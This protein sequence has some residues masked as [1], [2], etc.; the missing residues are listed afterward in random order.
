M[1]KDAHSEINYR[2]YENACDLI[3]EWIT[4]EYEEL[5]DSGVPKQAVGIGIR[6]CDENG[7]PLE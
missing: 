3:G 2:L 7:E 5:S 6:K 4:Y 1:R